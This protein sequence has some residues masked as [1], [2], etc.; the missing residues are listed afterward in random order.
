MLFL[1]V[2]VMDCTGGQKGTEGEIFGVGGKCDGFIGH[3]VSDYVIIIGC[4]VCP[5]DWCVFAYGDCL[6]GGCI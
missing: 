6:S 1:G 4:N 3:Y 2:D 5:Y